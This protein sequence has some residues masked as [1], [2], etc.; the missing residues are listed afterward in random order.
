MLLD[1]T[2]NIISTHASSKVDAGAGPIKVFYNLVKG[3]N[4][5]GYPYTLN[6]SLTS[7]RRLWVHNDLRAL[8]ELPP[9]ILKLL[10]PNLVVLPRDLPVSYPFPCS[11]YLHHSRWAVDVWTQEGFRQCP[12]RVWP[13]GIDTE[14][15]TARPAKK[16]DEVL[17]YY[18][19]RH[20]KELTHVRKKLSA[21]NISYIVMTCGQYAEADFI[22][23]VQSCSFIIWLGRQESQ[24]IALQECLAMNVPILV[25]D[26][27]TLFDVYPL[28]PDMFPE[29][30]RAFRTTAAPYFDDRCGHVIQSIDDLDHGIEIMRERFNEFSTREF[31]LEKLSL[32]KQAREFVG[33]FDELERLHGRGEVDWRDFDDR[34]YIPGWKAW[35]RIRLARRAEG[36]LRRFLGL[37]RK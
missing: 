25:I 21:A 32:E 27:P 5:I 8:T 19:Y 30:L 22:K 26:A 29:R 14:V 3:L 18:K 36:R 28:P 6:R 17:L 7:T 9:H 1:N 31:V 12:L 34:P 2:I 23:Q 37:I 4:K 24:G 11:F 10:G 16:S 35:F 33:L 13:V 20:L 15:F